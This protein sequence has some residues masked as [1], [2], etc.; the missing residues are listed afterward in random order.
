MMTYQILRGKRF[1]LL[2]VLP[3][4]VLWGS[5][6]LYQSKAFGFSPARICSN[7]S[8]NPDW[9]IEEPQDT[10][11]LKSILNQKFKYLAAGAQS[12]AFVSEDEKFVV[13]F[14]IMKHQI[15]RLSDLWHPEKVE[16]RKQNL[17]SI[18]KAH[19]LA[20]DELKSDTGLI[21][22]HLNKSHH[23]Q[24]PLQIVDRIGRTFLIDLD[25]TEFVIQE[26]AELIFTRL[27]KLLDQG[28]KEKVQQCIQSTL[29]LV[30]R[31]LEQRITD[32]DKAVKHNYGFVGDRAILLDIG[33]IEK[34][35][36]NPDHY[37]RIKQRIDKW[38]QENDTSI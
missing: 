23:L 33:R 31:R 36:P 25:Q 38:L 14:F 29:A 17:L 19:K 10:T 20:Y 1:W 6:Q 35:T 16:V 13:K 22:I 5:Y 7:F 15:P 28:D 27:K 32:Q 18:F 9:A 12:Y 37:K 24:T 2:L 26:K 8:Y 21:Y 4:V 34:T 30:Q 3:A 11:P